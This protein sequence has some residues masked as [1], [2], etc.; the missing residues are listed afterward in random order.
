LLLPTGIREPANGEQHP[1]L[2]EFG[3]G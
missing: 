3:G 1:F 2:Q